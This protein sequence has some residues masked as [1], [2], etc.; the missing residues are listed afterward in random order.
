MYTTTLLWGQLPTASLL[1]GLV[2]LVVS[3]IGFFK[4][5]FFISIGYGYSIAAMAFVSLALAGSAASPLTWAEAILLALYGLRL[6][7]YLA[8]REIKPAYQATQK[9]DGDRPSGVGVPIKFAI[10]ITVSVLYV[11][12]FMPTLARFAAES[13]GRGDTLP[14][15][16]LAGVLIT[17]LGIIIESMADAQKNRAKKKAP[18]RF[19]DSGLYR[20]SRYPNYFGEILVWTG[21]LIA[22]ASLLGNWILWAIAVLG[23]ICIFLIMIGSA[24]RLEFKQEERYGDD[25]EFRDYSK[26]TPIVFPL[27][28][29]YSLKNAK[30]YL[31]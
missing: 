19:C 8:L 23:Y 26:R 5:V 30:I 28:P 10:W 13:R 15:L 27:I 9:K 7:S 29:L 20:L 4:Y 16:S 14:G 2:A 12:M 25:P 18:R 1:L 21:N 3:S 11:M 17:T 31:G 24:R 22:G 6:G